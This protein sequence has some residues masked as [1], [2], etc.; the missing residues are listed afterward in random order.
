MKIIY[1]ALGMFLAVPRLFILVLSL[2][3]TVFPGILLKRTKLLSQ[4]SAFMIRTY[5][6]KF[7]II[8]LGIRI[9]VT[10]QISLKPG[11]LFVCNHR[12]LIDAVILFSHIRNG[13][14]ISKAELKDYPILGSGA[15]LS[16]II[17]VDRSN[18]ESRSSTKDAIIKT[19]KNNFSILL[20]PEGTISTERELLPFKK[21]GFEAAIESSSQV[22]PIAL[23]YMDPKSD[24]WFKDNI[25]VQF[26]MM[27]SKVRTIV[28]LHF[29][30]SMMGNDAVILCS[31]IQH[32][33]QNKVFEF[34]KNWK[35]EDLPKSLWLKV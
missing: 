24:F 1:Q 7:I 3:I 8:L 30:D 15:T 9:N 23:E 13:Y 16:G 17:Y 25:L 33:V 32:M 10:G 18:K 28:Q 4:N 22:S 34:Q 12:S 31:E 14:A 26:L 2:M 29:F 27:F 6:C 21:G 11:T 19:L 20:F 5:W 35:E